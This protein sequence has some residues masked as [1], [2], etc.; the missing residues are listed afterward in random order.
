MGLH[1]FNNMPH[2]IQRIPLR[3]Q[4]HNFDRV[5]HVIGAALNAWPSIIEVEPGKGLTVDSYARLLR[6]A[7]KAKRIYKYKHEAIDEDLFFKHCGDIAAST[8]TMVTSGRVAI[9]PGYAFKERLTKAQSGTVVENFAPG[10]HQQVVI[11]DIATFN[12]FC[13][14][15]SSKHFGDPAPTNFIV[16]GL[17]NELASFFESLYDIAFHR[18]DN[19]THQVL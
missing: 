7:V 4:K 12:H 6:E 3:Y 2:Q 18:L 16:K 5:A 11:Y 13:L 8:G 17:S 10:Q 1:P 19:D 14:M 15:W 9:G